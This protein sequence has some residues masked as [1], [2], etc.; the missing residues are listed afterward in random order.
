MFG[1]A[2]RPQGAIF[3]DVDVIVN[4]Q[5]AFPENGSGMNFVSNKIVFDPG[6]ELR[7]IEL[8]IS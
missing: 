2:Q 4:M 8:H 5:L 1:I 6:K 3:R 7:L